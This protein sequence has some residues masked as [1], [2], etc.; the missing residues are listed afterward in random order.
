MSVIKPNQ[1]VEIIG[2]KHQKLYPGSQFR[3]ISVTSKFSLLDVEL[4]GKIKVANKFLKPVEAQ[5]NETGEEEPN[6][7]YEEWGVDNKDEENETEWF[8]V[9]YR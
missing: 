6:L 3:V 4:V 5:V 9:P 7:L 8:A 1:I 2:G